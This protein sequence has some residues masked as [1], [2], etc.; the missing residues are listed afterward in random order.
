M[1]FTNFG[2]N[3]LTFGF[4]GMIVFTIVG[5]WGLL[6]QNEKIW[7]NQSGKLLSITWFVA[8]FYMCIAIFL[9]GL[10]QFSISLI[11]HGIIRGLFHIPILIGL[12]RFKGFKILEIIIFYA[13][14]GG[15]LLMI[16]LPMKALFFLLFSYI[17]IIA[18]STQPW[19]IWRKKEVGE[20]SIRLI[21]TYLISSL[22]WLL[23]S[24]A[25]D[26]LTM[27]IVSISYFIILLIITQL[28][29]KYHTKTI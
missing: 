29:F 1:E 23:Y 28:W 18:L 12:R 8:N 6:K 27:K 4:L 13:M 19:E 14:A 10:D 24:F 11:F 7:K 16:I 5:S 25:F 3:T 20:L 26:N 15:I 22:F 17:G 21:M 9:Y 2:W